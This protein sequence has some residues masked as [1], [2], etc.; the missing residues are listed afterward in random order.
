MSGFERVLGYFRA[1][2]RKIR[3][4]KPCEPA[5]VSGGF[6]QSERNHGHLQASADRRSDLSRGHSLFSD[7]VIPGARRIFLQRQPIETGDIKAVSRS[8]AVEPIADIRGNALL[9]SELDRP[10]DKA[11][12]LCVMHLR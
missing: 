9:A 12:L 4:N 1:G 7:G 2:G 5:K 11:L 10:G 3:S 6:F 8:P